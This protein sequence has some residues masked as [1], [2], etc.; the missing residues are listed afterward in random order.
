MEFYTHSR[1]AGESIRPS[2]FAI[3][4]TECAFDRQPIERRPL[5]GA[6]AASIFVNRNSA[7]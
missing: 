2:Q 4:G 1:A 3:A 5:L 7:E 6:V